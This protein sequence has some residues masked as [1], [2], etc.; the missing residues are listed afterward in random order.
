MNWWQSKTNCSKMEK[1]GHKK[2]AD[3]I[4]KIPLDGLTK[5]IIFLFKHNKK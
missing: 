2:I 4:I 1:E 3:F 5:L